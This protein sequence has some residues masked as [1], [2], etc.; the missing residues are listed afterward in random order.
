[1]VIAAPYGLASKAGSWYL[2]ADVD[3]QPRMFNTSR[4][5]S[6]EFLSDTAALRP[7]CYLPPT[8]LTSNR[9]GGC[10]SSVTTFVS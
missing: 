3:G 6:R 10:S 5:E 8:T 7:E 9:C 2:V 1:M 4:I